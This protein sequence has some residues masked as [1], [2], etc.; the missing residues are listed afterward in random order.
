MGRALP[1]TKHQLLTRELIL[2]L[3]LGRIDAGYFRGKF[4]VEIGDVF[5]EVF[6][7]LVSRG[8]ARIDGDEITL[9]REGLLQADGLLPAF[10]EPQFRNLR[11]S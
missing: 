5:R 11:Y 9:S 8:L 4:D 3:K 6:D 7:T 2:Q 1:V 10:F